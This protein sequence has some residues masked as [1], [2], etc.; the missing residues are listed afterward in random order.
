MSSEIFNPKR[1][2][3]LSEPFA[4][5][6]SA[7]AAL[8]AFHEA[9][10]ELRVKHHIPNL[11]YIA[12]FNYATEDGDEAEALTNGEFGNG[13]E[14]EHMLAWCLG[15]TQERRQQRVGELLAAASIKARTRRD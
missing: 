11:L 8:K 13:Y 4:S 2:R 10:S 7:E 3:E 9:V 12:K 5:S 14:H 6:E 15:K 1:Y